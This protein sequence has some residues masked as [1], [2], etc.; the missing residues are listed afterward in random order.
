M[1]LGI[2]NISDLFYCVFYQALTNKHRT[3][4][5]IWRNAVSYII[6]TV[7]WAAHRIIKSERPK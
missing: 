6:I 5:H 7:S 2:D 4:E 1:V 3:S